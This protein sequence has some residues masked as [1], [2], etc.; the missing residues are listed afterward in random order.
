MTDQRVPLFSDD[1]PESPRPAEA[2]AAPVTLREVVPAH[3][4]LT[5]Q[6]LLGAPAQAELDGYGP[7]VT[8]LTRRRP[9]SWASTL[10]GHHRYVQIGNANAAVNT[11]AVWADVQAERRRD[12]SFMRDV[13]AANAAQFTAWVKKQEAERRARAQDVVSRERGPVQAIVGF[14][15]DVGGS[16]LDPINLGFMLATGG[17]GAA[18]TLF[19]GMARHEALTM[20]GRGAVR[21]GG[22]NVGI[23]L[24]ETP[25]RIQNRTDFGEETGTADVLASLGIAGIAGAGFHAGG[26]AL[27]AG[28]RAIRRRLSGSTDREVL[29]AASVAV[30][31]DLRTPDQQAALHVLDREIATDAANPFVG[32]PQGADAH[33]ARLQSAEARL[34]GLPSVPRETYIDPAVKRPRGA[35]DPFANPRALEP[36]APVAPAAP[37]G[38]WEQVKRRIGRAESGGNNAARNPR[39]TALGTYQILEGTWLRTARQLPGMERSPDAWLLNQRGNMA[40]QEAVMDR[41]GA[42]Y[43]AKLKAVGAPETAGN[44]YLLHF[45]GEGGGASILRA[46]ADTPIERVM[47]AEAIAANPFLRGKT[48]GDVIAWAHERMGD[49]GHAGPVLRREQFADDAAGGEAWAD[50]QRALDAEER[51]AAD[52]DAAAASVR[53]T[54]AQERSDP[55]DPRDWGDDVPF[56]DGDAPVVARDPFDE[57]SAIEPTATARTDVTEA[58]VARPPASV[59]DAAPAV[60]RGDFYEISG[61]A[62]KAAADALGLAVT[63]DRAG[64]PMV[65][66][67]AHA[68]E[69]YVAELAN[70]GVPVRLA[71]AGETAP[72]P[73]RTQERLSPDD[74]GRPA[75][76]LRQSW[77]Y[78][79]ERGDAPKPTWALRRAD[80]K[81]V[82]DWSAGDRRHIDRNLAAMEEDGQVAPGELEAVR[83]HPE[84]DDTII[85]RS[86]AAL[87]DEASTPFDDPDSSAAIEQADGTIHDLEAAMEGGELGDVAFAANGLALAD[88]GEAPRYQSARE[89]LDQ[90]ADDDAALTALKACL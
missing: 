50:A 46:A 17:G 69:R 74:A 42:G 7:I 89:V 59:A 29:D 58:P 6:E 77:R 20:V 44:L 14:A 28:A 73:R 87:A 30:P 22:I 10:S 61:P 34:L 3:W 66:I 55:F 80:T 26:A 79:R 54:A 12:P 27:G 70:A 56:D 36:P 62:A 85:T 90:L 82:V 9:S 39:S 53:S 60:R 21:E 71:E 75:G 76:L 57:G 78:A 32:T 38:G 15:T 35:P 52:A 5:R 83:L 19:R 68:A 33:L 41:L 37:V 24:A 8:E 51:A 13:P 86:E 11:D 63:R 64:N 2:P 65:G 45:A 4:T 43:R 23:E 1:R 31:P 40:M 18:G 16:L 84:D 49:A 67:P 47:S 81:Q 48:T 25:I 88:G 72:K